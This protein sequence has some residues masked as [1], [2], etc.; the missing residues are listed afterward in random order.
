MNAEPCVLLVE[1]RSSQ[2]ATLCYMTSISHRQLRNDSA[3]VLRR[4][5]AGETFI[6][7]NNGRPTATIAPVTT[8]PIVQLATTGA[9]RTATQPPETLVAIQRTKSVTPT[10]DV[11]DDV[12]G[13]W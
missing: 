7:T 6:V 10:S 9:I 1:P 13:P 4:V 5:G 2:D 3:E 12:R 8:D 11:I